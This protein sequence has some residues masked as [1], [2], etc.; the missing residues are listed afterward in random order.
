L[1]AAFSVPLVYVQAL[2]V[3][4]GQSFLYIHLG[5]FM[6]LDKQLH[7]KEVTLNCGLLPGAQNS[8]SRKVEGKKLVS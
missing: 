5:F 4:N 6:V 3:K 7:H 1:K 2:I 8:S